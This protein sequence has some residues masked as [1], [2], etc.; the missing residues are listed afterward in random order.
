M[1]CWWLGLF[2]KLKIGPL[3]LLSALSPFLIDPE[4]IQSN[5]GFHQ[6][7]PIGLRIGE[8]FEKDLNQAVRKGFSSAPQRFTT[9][10][11]QRVALRPFIRRCHF[12]KLPPIAASSHS[13]RNHCG[14]NCEPLVRA[15]SGFG[16]TSTLVAAT[17]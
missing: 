8:V 16:M 4:A 3:E 15:Y 12:I 10:K 2:L 13:H 9:S 1:E 7:L 14:T 11:R 17:I 6:H 5:E